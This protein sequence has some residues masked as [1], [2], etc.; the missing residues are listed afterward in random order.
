[1]GVFV[2]F[3]RILKKIV[4]YY[5]MNK[6]EIKSSANVALRIDGQITR[7]EVITLVELAKGVPLGTTII[8]IGSYR[9]RSTVALALG[10]SL[11]NHNKVYAIDPPL[12][13]HG[14]F[15]GEYGP[16]DQAILY[17]NLYKTGVGRIVSVVSLSSISVA[18]C[19]SQKNVGL[20]WIDGDHRYD[21]VRTDFAAW[22][23]FIIDEGVIAF[24]D[25]H[26]TGVKKLIDELVGENIIMF[27][28]KVGSI[29]WYRLN[30]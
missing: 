14:I 7:E 23:P 24:H 3:P 16:E 12:E 28:G 18:Q 4:K 1:M 22:C 5:M 9:G 17:R 10:T 15:G 29:A 25:V 8:E 6:C 30:K 26:S 13:F 11:G 20:L 2:R 21:S 27:V 19:W